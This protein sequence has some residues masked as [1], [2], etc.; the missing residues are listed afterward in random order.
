MPETA[1]LTQRVAARASEGIYEPGQYCRK[2]DM[3]A[4]PVTTAE[5]GSVSFDV[6]TCAPNTDA[7]RVTVTIRPA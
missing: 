4:G 1:T 7:E 2:D 3:R 5:D 6:T